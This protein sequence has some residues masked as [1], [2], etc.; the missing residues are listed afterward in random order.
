MSFLHSFR[1]V[2]SSLVDAGGTGWDPSVFLGN[3]PI[4][5]AQ[6]HGF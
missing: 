6:S 5:M 1:A 4:R 3:F 2:R